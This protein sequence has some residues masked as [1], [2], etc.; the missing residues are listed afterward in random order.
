MHHTG[1]FDA[2]PANGDQF[3]AAADAGPSYPA[4][5]SNPMAESPEPVAP[6]SPYD[7]SPPPAAYDASPPPAAY[8]ASPPPAAYA[9]PNYGQ[10]DEDVDG[11][12]QVVSALD[13][14]LLSELQAARPQ[15][16]AFAAPSGPP[17]AGPPPAA[18]NPQEAT[19]LVQAVSCERGHLNPLTTGICRV[20]GIGLRAQLPVQV[21]RPP[22]GVLRLSTGDVVPLDRGVV[23]G[24]NPDPADAN[25][26]PQPHVVPV[27]SPNSD[28]SRTHVEISLDGWNVMVRDLDST[29]GTVVTVR[30]QGPRRLQ[31]NEALAIEPGT[32]VS[33][34]DEVT[35]VYEAAV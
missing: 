22:L 19:V 20:C 18:A 10:P 8:D 2:L 15:A 35:F 28:I 5:A 14:Q 17:V 23:I 4:E 7:A 24:R 9:E 1:P 31:P 32:M 12:T 13:L 11:R 30:W 34:A 25:A 29:N 21:P 6:V 3:A 26:G 16:S 33:M 27:P